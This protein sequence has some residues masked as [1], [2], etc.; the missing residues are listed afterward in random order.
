MCR[1]GWCLGRALHIVS[2]LLEVIAAGEPPRQALCVRL[3]EGLDAAVAAYVQF[4]T[5][6]GQCTMTCWPHSVDVLRLK[7]ALEHLP[8]AHPLLL[9]HLVTVNRSSCASADLE[10]GQWQD[11]EMGLLLQ[12]VVGCRDVAQV[13][14]HV[15]R[16]QLR[17][18]VLART[19]SFEARD[20]HVL[21]AARRPLAALESV[22]H[23]LSEQ[24]P[25]PWTGLLSPRAPDDA[26]ALTPREVEVLM[27]LAEGLLARTIAARMQVS[28]R[29]VHKHLGNV[30][31]KLEAHDRLM[32]VHRAQ[33]MGLIPVGSPVPSGSPVVPAPR[34]SS[35]PGRRSS[36]VDA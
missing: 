19:R 25:A 4:D 9:Q 16:H 7:V 2:D 14:L 13:P 33:L 21:E 17:L 28:P 1:D 12:E 6:K 23:R 5:E 35:L 10:T 8:R 29:T 30:Y 24:E 27:L 26:E 20:M 3:G 18:L 36:S 15:S 11:S 31:R 34:R 22:L 32:A